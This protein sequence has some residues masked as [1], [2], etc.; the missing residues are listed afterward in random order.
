[1]WVSSVALQKMR[2]CPVLATTKSG[3]RFPGMSCPWRPVISTSVCA[4]GFAR[5]FV[6]HRIPG[7]SSSFLSRSS[8]FSISLGM[9][10][11]G[12]EGN[13]MTGWPPSALA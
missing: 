7:R 12:R 13:R 2:P 5:A 9:S 11:A 10:P 8:H 1:M 6:N 3:G 4:V